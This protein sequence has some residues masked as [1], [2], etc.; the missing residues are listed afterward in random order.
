LNI[1]Y[2]TQSGGFRLFWDLAKAVSERTGG[3]AGF[4]VADSRFYE[5]YK[6]SSQEA[7]DIE[8]APTRGGAQGNAG[9][10]LSCREGKGTGRPGVVERPSSGSSHLP[11]KARHP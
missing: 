8:A 1:L 10:C 4:Y 2:L 7:S 6:R 3:K 5:A 9:H 11:G